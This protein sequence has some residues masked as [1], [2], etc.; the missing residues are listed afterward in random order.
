MNIWGV[1][2]LRNQPQPQPTNRVASD[3]ITEVVLFISK[4]S[5][6]EMPR[7]QSSG[8]SWK[9]TQLPTKTSKKILRILKRMAG[10]LDVFDLKKV[11]KN[12][13]KRV[14][15][16]KKTRVINHWHIVLHHFR[17]FNT[18]P[19]PSLQ[20][21]TN[22]VLHLPFEMRKPWWYQLGAPETNNQTPRGRG[23]LGAATD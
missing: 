16:E 5:I 18:Y 14:L 12:W 11:L 8:K 9:I 3:P 10:G 20:I 22:L 19:A 23:F 21:F 2:N 7:S 15:S 1:R 13:Q 4:I 6:I 17:L